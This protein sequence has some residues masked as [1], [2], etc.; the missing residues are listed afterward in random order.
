MRNH[1]IVRKVVRRCSPIRLT[2]LVACGGIVAVGNSTNADLSNLVLSAGAISPTFSAGTTNYTLTVPNTTTSTTVTPTVADATATVKVNGQT[3]TSG[4]ASSSIS[5]NVG[6]NTIN[7]VVTAQ[8]GTTTKTW[9][10]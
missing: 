2:S 6:S 9:S 3:V 5:L 10:S 8:D 4:T 1:V 7:T